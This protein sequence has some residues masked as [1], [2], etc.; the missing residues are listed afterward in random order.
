MVD[1]SVVTALT[2]LDLGD[3][4]DKPTALTEGQQ[5][6]STPLFTSPDGKLSIGIW[7]CT[8]GRFTADRSQTTEFCYFLQ[9]RIRMTRTDG[10]TEDLG[11]DD[12]LL[13]EKGWTGEWEILEHTRK[14]YVIY[15]G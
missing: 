5:E 14:V 1:I 4:A 11:P 12:S 6:A 8:P 15:A 3:L 13:L 7:E 2:G 10:T 9:G